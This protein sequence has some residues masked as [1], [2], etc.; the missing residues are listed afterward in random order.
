MRNICLQP[1]LTIEAQVTV[2]LKPQL[3]FILEKHHH[4]IN[5]FIIYNN[6]NI[7][8]FIH[9]NNIKQNYIFSAIFILMNWI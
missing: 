1:Y 9:R 8:Q 7:Q 5:Y 3:C 2:C 6:I 4:K